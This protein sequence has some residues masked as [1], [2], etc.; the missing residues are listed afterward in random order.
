MERQVFENHGKAALKFKD[1]TQLSGRYYSQKGD[2]RNIIGDIIKKLDLSSNDKCLDIGCGVGNTLIP[3]SFIVHEITGID[4]PNC[5]NILKGRYNGEN[6]SLVGENFMDYQNSELFDKI[7]VYSVMQ[8]LS[9]MK[10]VFLF[11]DKVIANLKL[12]GKALIG[13]IPNISLKNRFLSTKKGKDFHEKWTKERLKYQDK[14]DKD[15]MVNEQFRQ[16]ISTVIYDDNKV[17]KI[18]EYIRKKGFN[19]YIL[20]QEPILPFGNTREDILIVK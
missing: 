15:E 18:I 10:A 19:A 2:E 6:I 7:I 4:H 12:N 17:L 11:I 20:P 13:D 8:S 14:G 9:N 1:S 16:N 3:I 5:L